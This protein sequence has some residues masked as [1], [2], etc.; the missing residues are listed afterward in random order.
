MA[1]SLVKAPAVERFNTLLSRID[2]EPKCDCQQRG[3]DNK[4]EERCIDFI[5]VVHIRLLISDRYS[6]LS[7]GALSQIKVGR[8]VVVMRP[9]AICSQSSASTARSAHTMTSCGCAHRPVDDVATGYSPRMPSLP[10]VA[11]LANRKRTA[12]GSPPAVRH[13]TP[14]AT[15]RTSRSGWR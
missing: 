5:S 1:S 8:S 13:R 6:R 14:R 11:G 2:R 10:Y 4:S 12:G 9:K 15:K 3:Y 7:D